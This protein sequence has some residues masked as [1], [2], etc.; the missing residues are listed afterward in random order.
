MARISK[1]PLD[2]KTYKQVLDTLDLVLG[3]M[4]KDEVR[5]FLFSLLGRNERIMLSKRFTAILLLSHGMNASEVSRKL[6][7]TRQTVIRL[8]KTRGLKSRGFL[9][10][11]RKINQDRIA[12][13]INVILLGIAKETAGV[14]FNWRIKP[15]NDYP[16]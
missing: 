7:L 12:K 3:R 9:L 4:K 11:V 8:N 15:P 5:A 1:Y 2:N 6:N 14:F 16:K 10:A 13:E